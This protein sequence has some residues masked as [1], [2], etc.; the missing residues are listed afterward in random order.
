MAYLLCL[1]NQGYELSLTVRKVYKTLPDKTA[2]KQGFVRVVD[3]TGEDYC[4][5]SE[6]FVSVSIPTQGRAVF[7]GKPMPSAS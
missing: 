1:D 6:N 3:D 7:D 4:F 5:P 2:S